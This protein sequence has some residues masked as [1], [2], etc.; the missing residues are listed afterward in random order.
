MLLKM[1]ERK[2]M[3]Y[4]MMHSVCTSLSQRPASVEGGGGGGGLV[5]SHETGDYWVPAVRER[6][7][8]PW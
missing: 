3:L 1:E 8:A 5:F 4:L 6:D 2:V 7:V